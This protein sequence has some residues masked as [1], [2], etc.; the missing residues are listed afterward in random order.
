MPNIGR[1]TVQRR[2]RVLPSASR[3]WARVRTR[4]GGIPRKHV[5]RVIWIDV[6][7]SGVLWVRNA[8]SPWRRN[9]MVR[10]ARNR[11][12]RDRVHSR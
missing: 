2:F 1:E 9:A 12:E 7:N 8:Q 11:D 3:E 6:D 5:A 4:A 10:A